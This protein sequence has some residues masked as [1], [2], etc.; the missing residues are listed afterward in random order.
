M[1]AIGEYMSTKVAS[2]NADLPVVASH[3]FARQMREAV[4]FRMLKGVI[5]R[6]KFVRAS[7]FMLTESFVAPSLESHQA[8]SCAA[9]D[10]AFFEVAA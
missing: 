9:C 6:L 3:G 10:E 7:T 1:K 4:K 5:G 2:H 8:L